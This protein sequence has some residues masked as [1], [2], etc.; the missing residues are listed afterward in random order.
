MAS[1]NANTATET[2]SGQTDNT[3]NLVIQDYVDK[4]READ[5]KGKA[6]IRVELDKKANTAIMDNRFEEGKRYIAT[7]NAL[8]ADKTVKP[9]DHGQNVANGLFVAT[10]LLRAF[11]KYADENDVPVLFDNSD[12]PAMSDLVDGTDEMDF[13]VLTGIVDKLVNRLTSVKSD[14]RDIQG[15]MD[16][17]FQNASIG[18]A[19]RVSDICRIGAL[20]DYQ[21]GSGAVAARLQNRQNGQMVLKP[22]NPDEEGNCTLLGVI[23]AWVDKSG[24]VDFSDI[25]PD[26]AIWVAGAQKTADR[27]NVDES[28]DSDNTDD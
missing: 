9:V 6:A 2:F 3:D 15:V 19:L 5:K 24:N 17:A 23:P 14:R 18:D 25:C 12:I 7:R 11:R 13:S 22:T 4:Y 26:P 21:P 10:S 8:K 27:T 16:R 28:D 20:P 1:N